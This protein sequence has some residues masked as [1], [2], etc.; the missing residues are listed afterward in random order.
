MK[1]INVILQPI[2]YDL[3]RKTFEELK[4][5][6]RRFDNLRFVF[7]FVKQPIDFDF[8]KL[9]T[10]GLKCGNNLTRL[11][12]DIDKLKMTHEN[13]DS[14]VNCIEND[15]KK[16]EWL[17]I[18]SMTLDKSAADRLAYLL[19]FQKIKC[20][21]ISRINQCDPDCLND[22]ISRF[23]VNKSI[24]R[25]KLESLIFHPQTVKK[26]LA[27]IFSLPLLRFLEIPNCNLSTVNEI[28]FLSS[29][30]ADP[31]CKLLTLNINGISLQLDETREIL[32]E[33]LLSNKSLVNL[34]MRDCLFRSSQ[35]ICLFIQNMV[36]TVEERDGKPLLRTGLKNID[37]CNPHAFDMN[38]EA[39]PLKM[40]VH[41]MTSI[42]TMMNHYKVKVF[43]H[44]S[45]FFDS[46]SQKIKNNEVYKSNY[47]CMVYENTTDY[48]I[49]SI[50]KDLVDDYFKDFD[51]LNLADKT[52]FQMINCFLPDAV[53]PEN[54]ITKLQKLKSLTLINC[55]LFF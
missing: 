29:H 17:E 54:T 35:D 51:N 41:R 4:A 13:A 15:L 46:V 3:M 19:D 40:T 16:L 52:S 22:L 20:L 27:A 1:Q 12:I 6:R 21:S 43:V 8:W 33:A 34:T 18:Y 26:N 50:R 5:D 47:P 44:P 38:F 42:G 2:T 28:T 49:D 25:L 7:C 23:H 24:V 55:N 10:D 9:L 30:I 37:L 14:L 45:S 11:E 32:Q 53:I 39:N 36:T 31:K 48:S